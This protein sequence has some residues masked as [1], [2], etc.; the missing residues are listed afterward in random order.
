MPVDIN[1]ENREK[2]TCPGCPTYDECMTA[3]DEQI[4]CA[5]GESVCDPARLGCVCGDCPVHSEYGLTGTYY[6][7]EGAAQ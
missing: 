1:Q 3:E 6:C 7:F 4:Y 2:C 5:V